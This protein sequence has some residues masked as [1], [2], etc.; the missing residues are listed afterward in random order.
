MKWAIT[1]WAFVLAATGGIAAAQSTSSQS[2]TVTT[3]VLPAM[4]MPATVTPP[5]PGVLS[6]TEQQKTID[7]MVIRS[8]PPK[9]LTVTRTGRIGGEPVSNSSDMFRDVV[10]NARAQRRRSRG[11]LFVRATHAPQR[12]EIIGSRSRSHS[13]GRQG[14]AAAAGHYGY[15]CVG[16]R[17]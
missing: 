4:V 11:A 10:E 16:R 9:Q 15:R 12:G 2:T 6:T 7:A 8:I 17:L 13:G 5:P 3:T 1:A 14:G